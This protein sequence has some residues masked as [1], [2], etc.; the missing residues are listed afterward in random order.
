MRRSKQRRLSNTWLGGS[1]LL[2]LVV[3]VPA[4]NEE[5]RIGTCLTS[6]VDQ[7]PRIKVMVSDNSSEDQTAQ[8]AQAFS[9]R[10][11][12]AVRTI[13]QLGASQHFVSAGRWALASARCDTFALLAGDDSWSPDFAR[14]ALTTL[15]EHPEADVVYPKFLWEGDRQ[16]RVL[17]P[18]VFGQRT[19]TVRQLRALLLPD[20]RELAN[21]VY[22]VY[23]RNAFERMLTALERGGD[24]FGGDYAAVWSVLASHRVVTC[25]RAVGRRHTRQGVDLLERVG[26]RRD[27]VMGRVAT[28]K[29]YVRINLRIN[30]RI[31]LALQRVH[32]EGWCP[33]PWQLQ[34]L[35]APQW[36]VGAFR[37]IPVPTR[38]RA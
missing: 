4:R 8:C 22:G 13:T 10:M 16:V 15:A 11:D 24:E 35:R 19:R 18:V 7:G 21:L 23:R 34:L 20:R 37:H 27:E 3:V 1:S 14:A 31:A 17:R 33:S 29:L 9:T 6:L 5:S 38:H 28:A 25:E 12:L 36:L 32:A 2:D 26:F 30:Q